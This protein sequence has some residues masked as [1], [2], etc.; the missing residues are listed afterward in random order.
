MRYRLVTTK[1]GQVP[2]FEI[3]EGTEVLCAG[4]WVK[5]PSPKKGTVLTCSFQT[6]PTT[7]F[8]KQYVSG[9]RDVFCNHVPILNKFESHN[10]GL[11]VRGYLKED[12]KTYDISPPGVGV[13]LSEASFW[14][15]RLIQF[16]GKTIAPKINETTHQ[17]MMYLPFPKLTELHGNELSE[18]NLEYYLEGMLRKRMFWCENGLFLSEKLD[19]SARIVLRLLNIDCIHGYLG[20]RITNPVSFLKHVKDDYHKSKINDEMIRIMMTSSYDLPQYT[21]GCR[22]QNRKEEEDWILPGINPDVNCLCAKA[23]ESMDKG[24][25][26]QIKKIVKVSRFDSLGKEYK[27][28]YRTDNLWEKFQKELKNFSSD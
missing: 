12:R 9:K 14:Y 13:N 1:E 15:P 11:T 20:N 10:I 28:Q 25:N 21:P 19:E 2:I 18:R 5:A 22:I 26:P 16:F 23:W 8:A 3:K 24:I 4:K 7:S 27:N 17:L 6:L